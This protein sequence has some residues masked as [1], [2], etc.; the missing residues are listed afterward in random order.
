MLESESIIPSV[1]SDS[2]P[3]HGLTSFMLLCPWH[4]PGK[5]TG[6]GCHSLLQRIFPGQGL[7]S[8]L[9]HSRQILYHLSHQGNPTT[10][11]NQ[12]NF[13]SVEPYSV[14]SFVHTLISVIHM[15]VICERAKAKVTRSCSTLCD[16]MDYT[17]PG[18]L[19][20]RI[21]EWVAFRFSRGPSQP[22]DQ[23]QV[24]CIAGRFLTS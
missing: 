16:P 13:P 1:V 6:V 11:F 9:P 8:G 7:N 20:A 3:P 12:M 4:S 19:Q 18:I 21:L 5:N 15:H 2:L 10:N 14:F 17:V 23:T 24:S 22:R